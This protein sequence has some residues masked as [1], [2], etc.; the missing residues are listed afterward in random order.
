M[1]L[2]LH[3]VAWS[4][5]SNLVIKCLNQRLPVMH[6]VQCMYEFLAVVNFKSYRVCVN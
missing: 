2:I 4:I 3:L 1:Y 5:L 6:Y